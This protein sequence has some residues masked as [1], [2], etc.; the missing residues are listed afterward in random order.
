MRILKTV[1][2]MMTKAPNST[3]LFTWVI[4]LLNLHVK[5]LEN[6]YVKEEGIMP[7]Q[8]VSEKKKGKRKK[9][10]NCF[11]HS[12]CYLV[13]SITCFLFNLELCVCVCVLTW[14]YISDTP[15]IYSV[16]TLVSSEFQGWPFT[17]M[18]HHISHTPHILM[19]FIF[20]DI[21]YMHRNGLIEFKKHAFLTFFLWT[22]N[23]AS[24]PDKLY[25]EANHVAE[26]E[27]RRDWC[28]DQESL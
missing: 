7:C 22:L 12:K 8:F 17:P 6:E 20:S 24:P 13:C 18:Y 10:K 4:Q 16:D 27:K 2:R 28:Q 11:I 15:P 5:K 3:D 9:K 21:S 26:G 25:L 19:P 23:N 1:K 14:W